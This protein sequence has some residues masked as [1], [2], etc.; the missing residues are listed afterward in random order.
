MTSA[1]VLGLRASGYKQHRVDE[2]AAA[3]AAPGSNNVAP[4]GL[5]IPESL[6]QTS[7][8]DKLGGSG[9]GEGA[10]KRGGAGSAV[11][12]KET[13][14]TWMRRMFQRKT[15]GVSLVFVYV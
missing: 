5:G 7:T 3:A 10:G 11:S 2:A 12:E 8:W 13:T 1:C 9:G 4:P 14:A 6:I 15:A